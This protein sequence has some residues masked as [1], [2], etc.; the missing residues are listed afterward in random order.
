MKIRLKSLRIAFPAFDEPKSFG[1]GEPAYGGKL[2]VPP[3]HDAVK[4]LDDTMLAVAKE[5]WGEKGQSVYNFLVEEGKVC[6][7]KKTYRS[8]KSGDAYDG[9]EGNYYLS[10]RSADKQPTVLDRFGKEVTEARQ[11]KSLIYS[12]CFVHAMVDIWAQD[13]QYGRRIN[14]T[15]TGVMF[16]SD[17]DSFG[18]GAAPASAEDFKDL[19]SEEASDLV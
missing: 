15:P 10:L 13:N 6:F 11:I 5:K 17:G 14:C 9:F 4:Q 16:A 8:K 1:E 3:K 7:L 18:G 2:I 12:G 19:A